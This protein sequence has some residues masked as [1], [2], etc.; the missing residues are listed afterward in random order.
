MFELYEPGGAGC[1]VG[2]SLVSAV[3]DSVKQREYPCCC[4][5]Q[6]ALC[7]LFS[8]VPKRLIVYHGCFCALSEKAGHHQEDM[9]VSYRRQH[10]LDYGQIPDFLR[11]EFVSGTWERTGGRGGRYPLLVVL[12]VAC[13]CCICWFGLMTA[14]AV[15][16][17]IDGGH[18]CTFAFS[19]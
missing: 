7:F 15:S 4:A 5:V 17:S 2:L 9:R 10:A 12:A 11:S 16:T 13:A 8:A 14:T 6:C 1:W 19:S 3:R 18:L